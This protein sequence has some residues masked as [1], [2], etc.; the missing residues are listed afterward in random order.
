M[1]LG[2]ALETVI[3]NGSMPI[4]S[5]NTTLTGRD[6]SG[7]PT[8]GN[9]GILEFQQTQQESLTNTFIANAGYIG[10]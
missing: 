4:S 3:S 1:D 6:T 7:V 5:S 10:E 8:T 9:V 2:A